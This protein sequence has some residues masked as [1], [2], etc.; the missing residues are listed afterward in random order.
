M[1]TP[2]QFLLL[3]IGFTAVVLSAATSIQML[4]ALRIRQLG[5]EWQ[6]VYSP[7]DR[8]GLAGRVAE[9]FPMP[10]AADVF[11]FDVLYKVDGD[12]RR[13]LFTVEYGIGVVQAKTRVRRAAALVEPAA[14]SPDTATHLT[15]APELPT[16]L[17]QYRHLHAQP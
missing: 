16:L 15:V 12:V 2:L 11:V 7:E 14:P 6:M 13:Y 5:T 4:R 9:R 1:M 17:D 8:M 3:T 10:G